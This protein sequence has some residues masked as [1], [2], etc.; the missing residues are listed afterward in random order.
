MRLYTQKNRLGFHLLG[1]KDRIG[2]KLL[3]LDKIELGFYLPGDKDQT[4]DWLLSLDK[5]ETRFPPPR[6]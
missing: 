1:D 6:W 5:I 3:S 2:D 4:E